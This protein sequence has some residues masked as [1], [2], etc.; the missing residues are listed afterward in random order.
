MSIN[1][2]NGN[3]INVPSKRQG[4][5]SWIKKQYTTICCLPNG[6]KTCINAEWEVRAY[7]WRKIPHALLDWIVFSQIHVHPE[8]QNVTL[9]GNTVALQIKPRW[10]LNPQT[11]I[12]MRTEEWCPHKTGIFLRTCGYTAHRDLWGT[13]CEDWGIKGNK[14]ATNPGAPGIACPCRKMSTVWLT[15][16]LQ[17]PSFQSCGEYISVVRK[18]QLVQFATATLGNRYMCSQSLKHARGQKQQGP[19]RSRRD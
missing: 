7:R 14:L 18:H 19:N 2:L 1:T 4:K 13:S 8:P 17:T 6:K 10:A 3:G 15:A 5:T 11:S 16:G 9:L 12:F